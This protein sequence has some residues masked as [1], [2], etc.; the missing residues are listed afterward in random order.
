MKRP[1]KYPLILPRPAW[2]FLFLLLPFCALFSLGVNSPPSQAQSPG[3]EIV[4]LVNSFRSQLGLP[5]FSLNPTLSA[6]AQQ[7]ANYMAETGYYSHTGYGGSSPQSRATALGYPGRVTENIVG[8]TNLTPRQ[9]LIWW[10]NSPLHYSAIA[11]QQYTEIGFG[12]AQ[13]HDQNFYAIVVGN[14]SNSLPAPSAGGGT[15]D[16][17]NSN[18]TA[19]LRVNPIVLAQPDETGAIIHTIESGQSLWMIAAHY[20]VPVSDLYYINSLTES[21]ILQPGDKIYIRLGEGQE[22]PPTP[23]PPSTHTVRSGETLWTIA[24]R[25]N[26]SLAD[27]LWYNALS[28]DAVINP[29]NE[30]KIRLVEGEPLPPTPTPIQQ[31]IVRTGDSFWGIAFQYGISLDD[32]LAWNALPADALLLVGDALWI[33]PP[34]ATP[35]PEPTATI[36]LTSTPTAVFSSP[37]PQPASIASL[38]A[39]APTATPTATPTPSPI[40]SST[41]PSFLTSLSS[42]L[43]GIGL[44]ALAGGAFFVLSRPR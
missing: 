34:P 23:M 21:D 29:G 41:S 39:P 38:N 20:D 11:S 5:A 13:G 40:T 16:T 43:L 33:V 10:Q 22:P 42:I 37:T 36:E 17:N 31:H 32:L 24:A 1:P 3:A 7:Q 12:F 9:G 28:A 2:R 15:A 19:P 25:Y 27:L 8:G 30:L 35:T 6:A 14:P 44:I 26:I 18:S 4:Q